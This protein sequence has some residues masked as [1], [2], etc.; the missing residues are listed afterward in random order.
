VVA[1][2]WQSET[3]TTKNQLNQM[4][5]PWLQPMLVLQLSLFVFA[6]V[7]QLIA[8]NS[9]VAKFAFNLIELAPKCLQ[10]KEGANE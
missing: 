8:Y 2:C 4:L 3:E 5:L 7:S 10:V 9:K 6:W 1:D